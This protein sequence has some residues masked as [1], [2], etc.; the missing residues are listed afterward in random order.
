M[1]TEQLLPIAEWFDRYVAGF[2]GQDPYINANL[3]Y[4]ECHCRRVRALMLDLANQLALEPGGKV[5]AEAI[6]LLHD[7]GRFEQFVT[8]RTYKDSESVDHAALG[9]EVMQ[10]HGVLEPLDSSDRDLVDTAIR[11]HGA[12]ELPEGLGGQRSLF[13]RMIRDCDKLDIYR[14]ATEAYR[15]YHKDPAHHDL[16]VRFPD[17]P[18]CTPEVVQAIF[19][20]RSVAFDRLRTLND[21]KLM[22]IGWVYDVNF[23]ETL[24]RIRQQRYLDQL[25]SL[26]PDTAEVRRVRDAVFGYTGR[27][28]SG[29]G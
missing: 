10:R 19:E 4:K 17:E 23:P 1:L 21:L 29:H 5:L 8:Y 24:Q 16:G 18:S 14:I 12:R 9:A 6:G 28:L 2:Y 26:L 20:G 3:Q 22:Q 15:D 13:A 25:L 11:L 7:V 27:R